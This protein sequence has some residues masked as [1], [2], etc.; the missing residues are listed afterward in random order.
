MDTARAQAKAE[1]HGVRALT[2]EELLSDPEIEIV[3]NLTIPAAHF[4]VCRDALRAGKNVH[5]EKPLSLT[6]AEGQELLAI[7]PG[8]GPARGGRPGHIL[9]GRASDVPR[10]D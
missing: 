10:T 1:E 6:R 9:R 4:S 7:G 8:E 2:V 3:I 5:T